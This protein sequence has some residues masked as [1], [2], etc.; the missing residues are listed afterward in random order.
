MPS[1]GKV[2][3]KIVLVVDDDDAIV[4]VIKAHLESEDFAVLRSGT[5]E[6]ALETVRNAKVMAV[7]L[8]LG[9]PDLDGFEVLKKIK[10]VKPLVPVIIVTGCH[11]EAD[12]RRA[13]ELG[14]WD[15]VTKPIDFKYLKNVLCLER[16][17]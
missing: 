3:P 17:E 14:A 4:N 16:S 7:L 9:L 5:A 6:E 1:P 2:F 12:A 15:Y 11:E 10:E 8:D 13:F